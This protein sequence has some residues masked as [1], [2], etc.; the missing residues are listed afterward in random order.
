MHA[1]FAFQLSN[2]F[3]SSRYIYATLY[4]SDLC[5]P[6]REQGILEADYF[7][8][9]LELLEADIRLNSVI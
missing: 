3:D 7:I 9:V 1:P 5:S 8:D 4:C 2:F 6:S